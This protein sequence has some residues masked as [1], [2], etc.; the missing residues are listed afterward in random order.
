MIDIT[1]IDCGWLDLHIG[2][3]TF[4]VSYLTDVAKELNGIK[5]FLSNGEQLCFFDG[6]TSVLHLIIK[7]HND[8]IIVIWKE[9]DEDDNEILD[10]FEFNYAHFLY[11]WHLVWERIKNEYKENFEMKS[12]INK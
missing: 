11:E 12:F 7:K 10:K 8:N 6:E 1:N 3:R 4:K 2:D 5:N 9:Y